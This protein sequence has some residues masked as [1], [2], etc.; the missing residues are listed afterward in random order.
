MQFAILPARQGIRRHR[1]GRKRT[2][3]FRLHKAEPLGQFGRDQIAQGYV[4]AQHQ[5]PDRI[6]RLR[7]ACAHAHRARDHRN[8][9]FEINAPVGIPDDRVSRGQ[10]TVR[11]TLIH[12]R[13]GPKAFGH[14]RAPRFADQFDVI[15]VGRAVQ[16]L[17][18]ARQ[19]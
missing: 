15:D 16:K 12:Q 19:R 5:E 3:W 18:G 13:I 7:P 14:Y 11:S 6:Q 17:I 9:P 8:L 2:G 4:V 1:H 10:K